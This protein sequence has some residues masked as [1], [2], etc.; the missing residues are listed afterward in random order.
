MNGDNS[1]Y[2][3]LIT[4]KLYRDA[5]FTCGDRQGCIDRFENPV[6]ANVFTANGTKILTS[7]YL[8]ISA[9]RPL[10]DTLKNPC[11]APQAQHLEVAF[12]TAVIELEPIQG[13]Y[14]VSSQRCCRGEKLTNIY[15]SEHEGSTFFTVIP[16]IESRPGNNSAYFNKDTAI[17]ICNA[18][19]FT[20]DYAAYD[21]DGD[22]LTYN[23]CSALTDGSAIN[24]T[25]STTPPP[26]TATVRYIPPYSGN[27]PMGGNPSIAISSKGL[28][29]CTPGRAGK[30]VVTVCVNE[31]DRVTKQFLGTHSK[32]ILLTV[33]DCT[34]NIVASFPS[35]LN[36]CSEDP[37][38]QVAIP[39][40]STSGFTS[41]YYWT[42][43]DGTD[44][45]TR[46][47]TLFMHQYPDT[48]IYK[49]KLVV[50]PTL[51]CRDSTEGEVH[52]YPGL[53]ADFTIDGLCKGKP[54]QF[55]D[56][57]SYKYGNITSRA[58]DLGAVD[59]IVTPAAV[60]SFSYT[61]SKGDIYTISLTLHTDKQCEK[62]VTKNI[63]IYEVN[64]FAGNDTILARGQPLVMQGSG[65][66]IYSWTPAD[67]LSDPT[68]A[69]PVLN[70]NKDISFILRVSNEQGCFGYD[71]IS[72]KYYTGPEMYIPNAFTPN[73]DGQ[74]DHF[75]FI[76]VGITNYK[77]FRI[78]NRWG[79]EIY[80]STDFRTG[81]DG[82]YRG[83]PA[84]VDTYIWILQGTDFT[85]KEIMKK[86]TVTLIR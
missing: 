26:Y 6:S 29:S 58:W 42:F 18:I 61:F 60:R 68:I 69:H 85:G 40:Y 15:N 67:G 65:G 49:V 57:S 7:V 35:V 30:Y 74:N 2:R 11:L 46:N 55:E 45:L 5:D 47:K 43:G 83:M 78:Y 9:T 1:R 17:V 37:G 41:T 33:F 82:S 56:L 22:S 36:N 75:R 12:Y 3:Y 70:Y 20:L 62:T 72:V 63:H 21:E 39:N 28:I 76:P 86:G 53:K 31:Y 59:T 80:S 81:W 38:L 16:G 19:P 71:T 25:N 64:P 77:F 34:T 24:E 32:D 23:L 10:I 4:L 44:T 52:N 27:N 51:A 79:V 14:Y 66:D 8:Y 84:P 73:G 13:G 50:N 54:I 48:G